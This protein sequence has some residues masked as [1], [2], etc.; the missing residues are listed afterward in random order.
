MERRTRQL[1]DTAFAHLDEV[2]AEEVPVGAIVQRQ[3]FGRD[4]Y[5]WGMVN[6]VVHH[7]GDQG[8]VY[9]HTVDVDGPLPFRGPDDTWHQPVAEPLGCVWLMR[10]VDEPVGIISPERIAA[11]D[12]LVAKHR[13]RYLSDARRRSGR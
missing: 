2:P 4:T 3:D 11:S 6:R 10:P 1:L 5:T 8:L 12:A 9:I 13:D 7:P